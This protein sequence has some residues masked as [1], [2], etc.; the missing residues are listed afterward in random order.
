MLFTDEGHGFARPENRLKFY[1][2][3]EAFLAKYLWG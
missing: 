1:A 2:A 3:T